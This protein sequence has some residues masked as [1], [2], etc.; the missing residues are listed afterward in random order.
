[1]SSPSL[2][3]GAPDWWTGAALVMAVASLLILWSYAR[4]R[5]TA[6]VRVS[7]A[8]LKALA[9]ASLAF[10]LLEPL[11]TGSRPARRQRLCRGGGQQPEPADPRRQRPADPR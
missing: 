10:I 8:A 4:A 1:M 3:L 11:L 2:I 5:S 7:C 6:A 9:V